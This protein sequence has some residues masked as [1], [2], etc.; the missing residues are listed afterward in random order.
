MSFKIDV[1][2]LTN[3][4]RVR[5]NGVLPVLVILLLSPTLADE[6]VVSS[7]KAHMSDYVSSFEPDGKVH[8]SQLISKEWSR[9]HSN[10]DKSTIKYDV[11]TTDSLVSP[12]QGI[13]EFSIRQTRTKPYKTKEEAEGD[14][15][16]TIDMGADNIHRHTYL[17]SD[18]EWAIS[19]RKK[20]ML[21]RWFPC[22]ESSG[23][24]KDL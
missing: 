22:I 21:G 11:K 23:C 12:Y 19:E 6:A 1:V 5:R 20:Y 2:T 17:F 24:Y 18:G 9:L 15:D 13:L 16:L 7:F 3:K 14:W 10:I 8:V 4:K